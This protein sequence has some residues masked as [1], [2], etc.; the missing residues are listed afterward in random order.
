M[1]ITVSESSGANGWKESVHPDA[2]DGRDYD[3]DNVKAL[4]HVTTTEDIWL[5]DNHPPRHP[6]RRL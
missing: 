5:T 1:P 6:V 2:V 4:W 3:P